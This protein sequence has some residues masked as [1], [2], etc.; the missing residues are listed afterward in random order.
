VTGEYRSSST[1]ERYVEPNEP[2]LPDFADATTFND[3]ST[4]TDPYYKFRI[5][6]SK[7]F[8]P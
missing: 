6:G 8:T 2:G 5:I 7:K 1:L 4:D 3:P